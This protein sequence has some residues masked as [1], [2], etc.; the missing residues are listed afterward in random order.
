VCDYNGITNQAPADAFGNA[1]SGLSNYKVTVT[2]TRD[3]TVNLNGL[4]NN[5]GSGLYRVMRVD[6]TVTGPAGT[7]ITLSGYRTNYN[8]N[9]TSDP[10]CKT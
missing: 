4:N 8:C 9:S 2:V 7:S 6:V 10:G 3:N 1:L 5:T